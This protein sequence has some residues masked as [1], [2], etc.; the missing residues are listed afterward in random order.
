MMGKPLKQALGE[1]KTCI[2]R[3][4]ALMELAP[5]ALKTEQLP[6]QNGL[7]RKITREPVGVVLCLAPWN[8]PLLCAV[9]TVVAAVLAG[10][11]VVLKHSDRTPLCAEHFSR[12]FEQIGAPAGLVESLHADHDL[13]GR[14]LA[15]PK[16]GFVSFTG[17][18]GGGRAV[19]STTAKHRFIDVGLEL[20]GKDPA[21]VTDD[22]DLRYAIENVVDGGLYNAGQSCC[23]VERV[24]VHRKHYQEFVEGARS[25]I[26]S[27]VL[28]DPMD[29]A[30]SLGPLAQPNAPA[31]IQKKIDEAVSQGAK[32]VIGGKATTDGKGK[33]RFLAP[34]LLTDVTNDMRIIKEETFGPVVAVQPVDSDEQAVQLM[35]D[36]DFGLTASVWTRDLARAEKLTGQL[37]AGTVFM[38]RCDFLDPYLPWSGRKDSGKGIGL[39]HLCFSSFTRTKGYN[40]R[41]K[42][43]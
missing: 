25:L 11:S 27:Y 42:T 41:P 16:I 13:V 33:G 35:N 28:G 2:V 12:A 38:N 34:T 10:N 31:T 17:S 32:V 18:V 37:N 1:V 23:A 26:S 15:N 30:T 3:A 4:N 19:Y 7:L 6:E 43:Q 21:Y 29:A 22:V 24:Y 39:S 9:N 20:G 5:Q 36:S 14:M 40:F 8:Y